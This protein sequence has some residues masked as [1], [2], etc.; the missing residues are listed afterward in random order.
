MPRG[1]R[2]LPALLRGVFAWAFARRLPVPGAPALVIDDSWHGA[3][4]HGRLLIEG[5]LATPHGEIDLIA[6]WRRPATVAKV[7]ASS[8]AAFGWLRDL[9]E[10]G[11]EAARL[12]A[13]CAPGLPFLAQQRWANPQGRLDAL[14]FC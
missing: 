2:S 3:A 14:I 1:G 10:L 7:A 6:A 13:V 8:P 9:R 4:A 12:K 11:G 5:R